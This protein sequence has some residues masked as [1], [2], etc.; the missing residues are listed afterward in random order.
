MFI[1]TNNLIN[2]KPKIL[3]IDD[4]P[5][6][7]AILGKILESDFTRLA[8]TSGE[9]AIQL[10]DQSETVPDAILLDVIMKDLDGFEVCRKIKEN[11]RLQDIPI[12]MISGLSDGEN[13]QRAL[14]VGCCDYIRKP[15]ESKEVKARI[16]KHIKEHEKADAIQKNNVD[17]NLAIDKKTKEIVDTQ[18]AT[19]F[20]LAKLAER[21]DNVTGAHLERVQYFS[22]LLLR[23]V[24][25]SQEYQDI[26]NLEYIDV[27]EKAS[28]LHD[29]GKVAIQDSILLKEGKLTVDEFDIMKSHT[30]IGSDT[31]KEVAM[32]YPGN[33][34][35]EIGIEITRHHHERW[36]GS[37]YPDG[38]SKEAIP[39]S[40]RVVS[41]ADVYDALRSKR[42]YKEPFSHAKTCDIM[43][44]SR[45][46]QFDPFLVDVFI[47][48]HHEFQQMYD[49]ITQRHISSN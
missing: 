29:I 2:Q 20:A 7:I 6:T 32:Q 18:M 41:I 12:I 16:A 48:Y 3:I 35:L 49:T 8:T 44:N 22:G 47:R 26:I 24:M 10:L 30:T 34:F 19:I 23:K 25:E 40:A 1:M 28:I 33:K 37:G 14:D 31:L 11:K 17:L 15:F 38:I 46:N 42:A 13:I 43:I 45:G 27:V 39:L 9:K 21:R 36:N 4:D 5:S